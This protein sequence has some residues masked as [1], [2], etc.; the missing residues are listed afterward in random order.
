M[1]IYVKCLFWYPLIIVFCWL[2]VTISRLIDTFGHK[3]ET[4]FDYFGYPFI[5]L[6]GL[7]NSLVIA[8]TTIRR[9]TNIID[10]IVKNISYSSGDVE[11]K[12]VSSFR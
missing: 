2:F 3:Q 11:I 1:Q 4:T 7:L 8:L 10:K 9:E 6:S 5:G 12:P